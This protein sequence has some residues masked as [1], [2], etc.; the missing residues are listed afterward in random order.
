MTRVSFAGD[1]RV[2][3]VSPA[4][5]EETSTFFKLFSGLLC[6]AKK[7]A[8]LSSS[9]GAQ[10]LCFELFWPGTK[11]LVTMSLHVTK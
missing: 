5:S 7:I 10:S 1:A 9:E 2:V 6:L 11:D 8:N 4:V 3:R